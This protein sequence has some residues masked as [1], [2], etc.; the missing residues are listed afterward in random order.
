MLQK[1]FVEDS[2]K[3]GSWLNEEQY[4]WT[5]SVLAVGTE[6][7]LLALYDAPRKWRMAFQNSKAGAYKNW[8]AIVYMQDAK[9]MK[10]YER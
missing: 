1:E 8:N 10:A 6:K 9:M 3:Q 4:E 7:R 2:Y 5:S